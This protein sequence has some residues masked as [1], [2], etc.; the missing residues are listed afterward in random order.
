M[1]RPLHHSWIVCTAAILLGM[2]YGANPAT[3]S[4]DQGAS[5]GPSTQAG[6][7]CAERPSAGKSHDDEWLSCIGVG[8]TLDRAPSVGET[9]T[10]RVAVHAGAGL[11]PMDIRI[12]LPAELAWVQ[13]PAGFDVDRTTAPEPERVGLRSIAHTTRLLQSGETLGL[14]GE[15]RAVTAGAAT[16]EARATA[17]DGAGVQA[18]DDNVFLTVSEP[19]RPSGFGHPAA[20]GDL[21][22][23]PV[24]TEER[25]PGAS[26]LQPQSVGT[27]GLP[28]AVGDARPSG[29]TDAPCD[30][31]VTGSW[32]YSD[33]AGKWHNQMNL[34]VQVWDQNAGG[35][36]FLAVGLTDRAGRYN[37]CF[38]SAQ[39]APTADIYVRFVSENNL[40]KVQRNRSPL[41]WRSG[42]TRVAPGGTLNLGALSSGDPALQRGL[43]AFD[44]ANDAW[45]FIPKSRNLCFDQKDSTCRQLV[46]NWAPDSTDGTYYSLGTNDVHL[47]ANDP[48]AAA[49]TVHE[50]GHAIM[51][52]VYNDSFPSAPNCNPHTVPGS[53][54]TG[55][56]WTEG[57]AEWFP[58]TVYNDPFFRW[59]NGASLN[60]ETP[61]WGTS[62]WANGD[63][64]EGRVAGSMI[65]ITDSSNEPRYDVYG[66]GRANL[67]TTF[68]RHV[69][70][71]FS[72][73]WAQRRAD[74]FNVDKTGALSCLY[75]NTVNYGFVAAP[76]A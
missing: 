25:V 55:C 14:T 61:T 10:L 66:E 43:H 56:A 31:R 38:D 54:S 28:T 70:N 52:D 57:W 58:A 59:P 68:T 26:W 50:S 69:S 24:P 35:D 29:A 76:G 60:L 1:G 64:V 18:G 22:T 21:A 36:R 65:D 46:I 33:Q 49:V 41:V 71:T 9:A 44:E 13:V 75:Q 27:A 11:G 23:A 51:D 72:E 3:A 16:I 37:L 4:D 2:T 32:T 48:N 20:P 5:P 45:L 6:T 34:Q 63:T 47:A 39:T 73:F 7:S 19:G 8:A 42:T 30:T 53:T 15:V 67:W 74:G 12:D 62:G 17:S 40:W